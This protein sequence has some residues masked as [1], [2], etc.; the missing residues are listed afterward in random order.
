VRV[1]Q[2]L[3]DGFDPSRSHPGGDLFPVPPLLH[4]DAAADRP[5]WAGG[6]VPA[7]VRPEGPGL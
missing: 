7:P 2:H 5:G 3:R 4:G 1:R 6:T